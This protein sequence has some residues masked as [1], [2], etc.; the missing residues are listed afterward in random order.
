MLSIGAFN[1]LLKTLEE[2]PEHI[3]FVLAT[4]DVHKVPITIISRC[5]CFDFHRLTEQ[6]IKKRL[7]YIVN[8][9]N[10][11]IEDGI[12]DSIANLCDGGLRDAIG[13]LDKINSYSDKK[14]TM[15]DFE[16]LN[17]IV[18]IDS[19]IQFLK[20]IESK[21]VVEVIKFIDKIYNSGK[22]FSIF[23]QDL[24]IL[25]RD[26][27][28]KYYTD[29][30][31]EFDI[32]FLLKFVDFFSHLSNEIKL[33]NNIRIVF[34]IKVLSF[35]N[36]VEEKV[37]VEDNKN[38]NDNDSQLNNTKKTLQSDII[39]E[40]VEGEKTSNVSN[41]IDFNFDEFNLKIINNCFAKADKTILNK[42]KQNWESFN[43][44]ALDSEYG[45]VACYIVDGTIRAASEN[46]III[47]FDYESMVNRGYKILKK[48]EYLFEKIFNHKYFIAII[49]TD[50]WNKKK[51]EYIDNKNKGIIYEY[52]E[53]TAFSNYNLENNNEVINNNSDSIVDEAIQLFGE[54]IVTNI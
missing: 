27:I 14:I 38:I 28:I 11:E 18:S 21:N 24:L 46:E 32:N 6:E 29:G 48:I 35:M 34:E 22:D 33:S 39:V 12:L 30:K 7:L 40:K 1:A 26:M 4:T 9:E 17:G 44:Y 3:V 53:L 19:K 47:T 36:L 31:C 13:M 43:D 54:S 51:Q 10:I 16:E 15:D 8:E 52:K 23:C 37:I 25:C 45:S 20:L 42:L 49:T 5:Q 2:P 50:D 41:E